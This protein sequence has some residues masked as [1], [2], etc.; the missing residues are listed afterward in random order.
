MKDDV[1]DLGWTHR[2]LDDDDTSIW[3]SGAFSILLPFSCS[4]RLALPLRQR[5]DLRST[6][7]HKMN[8]LFLHGIVSHYRFVR[9]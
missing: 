6:K 8:L 2:C 4:F 7:P 5:L 9:T 1:H 3:R